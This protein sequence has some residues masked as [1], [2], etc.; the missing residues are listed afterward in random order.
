MMLCMVIKNGR[1]GYVLGA[2]GCCS[3]AKKVRGCESP[4]ASPFT[5]LQ[6]YSLPLVEDTG[7]HDVQSL[8]Y[9]HVP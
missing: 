1:K 2:K 5:E 9:L 8:Y 3:T 7:R 4:L 6:G